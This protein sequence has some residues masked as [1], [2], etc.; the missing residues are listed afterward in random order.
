[1]KPRFGQTLWPKRAFR[2]TGWGV[3][4]LLG[5]GVCGAGLLYALYRL[6]LWF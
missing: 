4:A 1:M 2:Y 3:L 5:A 6:L